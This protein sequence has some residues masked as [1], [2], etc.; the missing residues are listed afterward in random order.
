MASLNMANMAKRSGSISSSSKNG[1]SGG[2]ICHGPSPLPR[3]ATAALITRA[4]APTL[5]PVTSDHSAV[6]AAS[7]RRAV[8]LGSLGSIAST[9]VSAVGKSAWASEDDASVAPV[10]DV[11]ANVESLTPPSD[12]SAV[13]GDAVPSTPRQQ[14]RCGVKNVI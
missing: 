7:T 4:A 8:V 5:E 6:A 2:L 11:P 13:E 9:A 3:R 14:E 12:V 1:G 10:S